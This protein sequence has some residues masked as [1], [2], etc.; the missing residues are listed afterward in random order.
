MIKSVSL[1]IAKLVNRLLSISFN[2][3]IFEIDLKGLSTLK[4]LRLLRLLD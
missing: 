4:A 2:D 3:L 1:S